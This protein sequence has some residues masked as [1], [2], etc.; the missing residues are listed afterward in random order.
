MKLGAF[1][2]SLSFKDIHKSKEFYAKLGFTYKV[3]NIEQN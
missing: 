3:G 1:A 2:V